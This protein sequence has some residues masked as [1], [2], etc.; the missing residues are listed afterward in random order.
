VVDYLGSELL[1]A[2]SDTVNIKV[3]KK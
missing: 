1:K 3:V 2:S